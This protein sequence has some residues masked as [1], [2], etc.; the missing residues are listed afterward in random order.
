MPISRCLTECLLDGGAPLGHE[1]MPLLQAA[2]LLC[3]GSDES[4][5]AVVGAYIMSTA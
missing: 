2:A 5:H 1:L 4:G 3:F